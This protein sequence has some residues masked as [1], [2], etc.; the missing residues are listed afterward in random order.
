MIDGNT[1]RDLTFNSLTLVNT[2]LD[3]VNRKLTA[4]SLIT[5]VNSAITNSSGSGKLHV[6]GTASIAGSITTGRD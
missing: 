2:S 1:N 6:T 5:D 3:L 4:A